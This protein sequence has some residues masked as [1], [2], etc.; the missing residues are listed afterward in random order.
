MKCEA[1]LHG[2]VG[3]TVIKACAEARHI[4]RAK[5]GAEAD[6]TSYNTVIKACAEARAVTR[7]EPSGLNAGHIPC[8]FS[9]FSPLSNEDWNL[10]V[11]QMVSQGHRADRN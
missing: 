2:K 10:Q 6:T 11:H 5:A 1:L 9:S 4:A 7:A 8:F 3:S